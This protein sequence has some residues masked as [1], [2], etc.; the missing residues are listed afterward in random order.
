MSHVIIDRM[1]GRVE[2]A[3]EESDTSYLLSLLY[4][5]EQITKLITCT[6]VS[7]LDEDK[8][9]HKYTQLYKLVRADGIGE[10]ASSIDEILNGPTAHCLMGASHQVRK[11]LTQKF[12]NDTWQHKCVY[13][14]NQSLKEIENEVEDISTA[15]QLKHW[16][17]LFARLRNKTRGHGAPTTEVCHKMSRFLATSIKLLQENFIL[18]KYEWSFLHQNYS[19]KYKVVKISDATPN[20]DFLK[21]SKTANFKNGVYIFIEKIQHIELI[22][23]DSDLNDFYFP[24]GGF[25]NKRYEIL[26]YITGEKETKDNSRFLLPTGTLPSSE[27]EGFKSLYILGNTFTNLPGQQ[28]VYV[29][30]VEL[31]NE[32]KKILLDQRHP[33]ITLQGKGGIGKT[34]LALSVLKEIS[35]EN[36]FDLILWFSARDIDLLEEGPKPVRPDILDEVDIANDFVKLINPGLF[37]SKEEKPKSFFE[38]ELGLSSNGPMLIVL[39]NFETVRDPSEL[40]KWLDTYIRLPNKILI[41]TRYREFKADYPITVS[42]MIESEFDELVDSVSRILGI[43][44]LLSKEYLNELY[45]ESGGHPYVAKILLGEV[46][47]DKKPGSIKRIVASQDEILTALFE[48]TYQGLSLAAKRIFLTLSN[49]RSIIPRIG[50]EAI[51]RRGENEIF[52]IDEAIDELYRTSFIDFIKSDLD[53]YEFISIPLSAQLFGKSKLSVSALRLSIEADTQLLMLFGAIQNSQI[54]EGFKPRAEAFFRGIA[55]IT[56]ENKDEK[57]ENYIPVLKF[58][59]RKHP[60]SWLMLAK[61]LEEQFDFKGTIEALE[62]YLQ[63]CKNDEMKIKGWKK[64]A[65]IYKKLSSYK[66]EAYCLLELSAINST[67]LTT[68]TNSANRIITLIKENRFSKNPLEKAQAERKMYQILKS[69]LSF[70]KGDLDDYTILAWLCLHLQERNEAKQIIREVLRQNPNHVHASKLGKILKV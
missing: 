39:D 8:E 25:G 21:T 10:W 65:D 47:K 40:F 18:F 33:V 53:G 2:N 52:D 37:V 17:G 30:R 63:S 62:S 45:N 22:E 44:H 20:F 42:G 11:E 26:S 29:K 57:L 16:F 32:L 15:V 4:A 24:N 13:F 66:E 54:H 55:K 61:L 5:G 68:I 7:F 43:K 6:L 23:S 69:K 48:R 12:K 46:A 1:W 56:S 34:T 49:W 9:M 14:L 31:E 60:P 59:C 70:E 51:L 50:L 67:S 28:S 3:R 35:L 36:R 41:T 38:K 64:L 19:G 58:I 27:T